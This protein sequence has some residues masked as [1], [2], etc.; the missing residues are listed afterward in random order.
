MLIIEENGGGSEEVYRNSMYFP[1]DFPAIK[2][3]K[4]DFT[5]ISLTN[6]IAKILKQV[7]DKQTQYYLSNYTM[8]K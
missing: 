1:L 7:L 5:P 4:H 6:I 3:K 2:K 8:M